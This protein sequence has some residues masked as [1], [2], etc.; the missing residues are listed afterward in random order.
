MLYY[1]HK[2][3]QRF[4]RNDGF[5]PFFKKAKSLEKIKENAVKSRTFEFY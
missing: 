2:I 5:K 4:K 3:S 1:I